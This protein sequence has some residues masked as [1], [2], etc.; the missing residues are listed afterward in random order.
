MYNKKLHIH[1]V[2]IG[3]I[4]MS[5]IAQIVAQQGYTVSGSDLSKSSPI[6]ETLRSLGCQ[7][8]VGHDASHA[9]GA[10][11]VVYS[12]DVARTNPEIQAALLKG[13]P[14]IP[15]ALMLAE[16][17]RTKYSVAI[18]G[19]HGKTTTTSMISHLFLQAKKDPTILIGGI[20]KNISS[21]AQLGSSDIL[22]A[23]ADESDRSF[24]LLNPTTAIVTNIDK[25]HLNNYKD[26]DDIRQAFKDFLSR[27]PFYGKGIICIDD[28]NIRSILPLPHVQLIKYGLALDAD[29]RGEIIS[30]DPATSTINIY[31]AAHRAAQWNLSISE[32]E[33]EL[34]WGTIQIGVPGI[35]NVRNGLAAIALGIEYGLS[36]EAI[37]KGL[38]SFSGVQRRFEFKGTFKGAE[39]FDDYGHHPTE[40]LH[41]VEV[42]KRR[43]KPGGR[44]IV[45]FE[46]HRYSRMSTLW[47]DFVHVLRRL[48]VD[49]ICIANIY[50]STEAPMP[51][52][53]SQRLVKEIHNLPPHARIVHTPTYDDIESFIA[54]EVHENDL[55]VTM[56]AGRIYTV[57][58]KLAVKLK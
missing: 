3:G 17:M 56:G 53:T 18:S 10:D 4:G 2:G 39:I 32:K 49:I 58:E 5:G 22:I 33:K 40:I 24:L 20:L 48:S 15:R 36:Y 6:L 23:E 21:H 8:F 30:L 29:I 45:L 44:V 57:G 43:V 7:L 52:I 46:P 34:F 26:L 14:V 50:G 47:P 13:I 28:E 31:I 25:E 16:L 11:V 12:S 54:R 51:E 9:T 38:E 19:A 35:H 55:I 37:K 27:L 41:T 42:A 1:F